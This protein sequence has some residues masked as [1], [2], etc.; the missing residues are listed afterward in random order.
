MPTKIPKPPSP[1]LRGSCVEEEEVAEKVVEDVR[2]DHNK[3]MVMCKRSQHCKTY[4]FKQRADYIMWRLEIKS[5][6]LDL[7]RTT[8]MRRMI[9]LSNK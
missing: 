1:R 6:S 5:I 7:V 8:I 9:M 3:R 4:E 2:R